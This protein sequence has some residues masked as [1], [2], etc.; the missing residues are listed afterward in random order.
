M[1]DVRIGDNLPAW[2]WTLRFRDPAWERRWEAYRARRMDGQMFTVMLVAT[3]AF[4]FFGVVDYAV[5]HTPRML[6][7]I[8]YG[9]VFPYGL[10]FLLLWSRIPFSVRIRMYQLYIVLAGLGI[11]AMIWV[12]GPRGQLYYPGLILLTLIGYTITGLGAMEA[13][14]PS[15][16]LLGMG[17]GLFALLP[18]AQWVNDSVGLLLTNVVGF[19]GSYML[20]RARRKEF[21]ALETLRK[22]RDLLRNLSRTDALTG[23]ANRRTFDEH[24]LAEFKKAARHRIPVSLWMV[25]V[26]DFKTINDRHGHAAGDAV[27]RHV[28]R[29]LQSF[30]RR[31]GDLAARLGGDEFALFLFGCDLEEAT[32][33]A[34]AFLN[35]LRRTPPP[36]P[37]SV[38]VGVCGGIPPADAQAL[39]MLLR[40]DET[41]YVAKSRGKDQLSVL[42]LEEKS[43]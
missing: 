40:A 10:A 14:G 11:L 16:L 19:T 17:G 2:T 39:R 12:L 6:W 20:E 38:S 7:L 43:R 4:L 41:L 26:D 36:Y 34:E 8:R 35:T 3:V 9:L 30:A 27:L 21:W 13:L 31:T 1:P 22:E 28:G 29:V 32:R 24:L 42:P 5:G 33:R 15:L 25:D 23:L 37:C 18:E